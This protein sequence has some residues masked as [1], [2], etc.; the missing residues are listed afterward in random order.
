MASNT[1]PVR[2][3][4]HQTWGETW[5]EVAEA[6]HRVRRHPS[7]A[8]YFLFVIAGLGTAGAWL[9]WLVSQVNSRLAVADPNS[10]GVW[11]NIATGVASLVAAVSIDFTLSRT[12]SST[13]RQFGIYL[14]I[15]TGLLAAITY[16]SDRNC[17]S[18]LTAILSLL[19]GWLAWILANGSPHNLSRYDDPQPLA[20]AG[21]ADLNLA[22]NTSGFE[23]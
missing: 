18:P 6:F 17:V 1:Q 12:G 21:G 7:V 5:V 15:G 19:G 23:T 11:R 16:L 2:K 14:V 13:Y 20:P 4:S 8:M 9:P 22:G 10:L 3:N